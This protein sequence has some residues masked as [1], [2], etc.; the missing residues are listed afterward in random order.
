MKYLT[1]ITTVVSICQA[2]AFTPS[3]R[4]TSPS[5]LYAVGFEGKY[6]KPKL[7]DWSRAFK[8]QGPKPK[9]SEGDAAAPPAP[10][11]PGTTG[12][13]ISWTKGF[14]GKLGRKVAAPTKR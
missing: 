13:E 1:A 7:S 11:P 10:T 5:S 12:Q 4:G 9:P 8:E 6:S 3:G 14:E 2:A